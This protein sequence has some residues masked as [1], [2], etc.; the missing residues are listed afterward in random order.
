MRLCSASRIITWRLAPRAPTPNHRLQL[1]RSPILPSPV[2]TRP[3][4]AEDPLHILSC[5][6]LS[7]RP[8]SLLLP[9]DSRLNLPR[10]T[11]TPVDKAPYT[12]TTLHSLQPRRRHGLFYHLI[13]LRGLPS[14]NRVAPRIA[15]HDSRCVT[16]QLLLSTD[17]LPPPNPLDL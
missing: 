15:L 1:R 3:V 17:S 7:H 10:G 11:A 4:P 14:P 9:S 12:P 2:Q 16:L 6:P 13:A 8:L 5:N